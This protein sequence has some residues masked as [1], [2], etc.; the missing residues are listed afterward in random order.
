MNIL[1]STQQMQFH[2]ENS[3]GRLYYNYVVYPISFVSSL[4]GWSRG[5]AMMYKEKEGERE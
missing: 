1:H 5:I 2:K 4:Q 3:Q